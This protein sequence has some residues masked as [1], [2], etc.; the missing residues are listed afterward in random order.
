[1][2]NLYIYAA[3]SFLLISG[4]LKGQ[5]VNDRATQINTSKALIDI[6]TKIQG[7]DNSKETEV[8]GTPFLYDDWSQGSITTTNGAIFTDIKLKYNLYNEQLIFLNEK[9]NEPFLVD[10]DK[11]QEFNIYGLDTLH[12]VKNTVL[13]SI[14]NTHFFQ[15]LYSGPV[16]LFKVQSKEILQF[17]ANSSSPTSNPPRLITRSSLFLVNDDTYCELKK[18]RKKVISCFDDH[19]VEMENFAKK[20]KLNFNDERDLVKLFHAYEVIVE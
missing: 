19:K 14:F 5:V 20:N 15:L 8:E 16:S 1:M 6:V 10:L 18:G 12:F 2:K 7:L 9:S 4:N 17:D 11:L 3:F 13:S